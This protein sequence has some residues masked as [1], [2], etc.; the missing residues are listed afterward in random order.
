MF[1]RPFPV[2]AVGG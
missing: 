2:L 1:Q